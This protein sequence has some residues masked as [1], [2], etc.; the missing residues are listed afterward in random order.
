MQES[1]RVATVMFERIF[2]I[3]TDEMLKEN[4]DNS[5]RIPGLMFES[6]TKEIPAK[7]SEGILGEII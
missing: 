3:I 7:F 4:V 5:D 1:K 2:E 6:I